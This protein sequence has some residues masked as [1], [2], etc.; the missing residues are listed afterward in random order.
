MIHVEGLST[1]TPEV[2]SSALQAGDY[3]VIVQAASAEVSSKGSQGLKLEYVVENG[4]DQTYEK[5]DGTVETQSPVGR[6]L[7]ETAWLP[8]SGQKDGGDYCARHLAKICEVLGVAQG[9]DLDEQEFIGKR[10]KVR[11]KVVTKDGE[12]NDLNDPRNEVT[13]RFEL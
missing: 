4:P 9:D 1:A 6:H 11:V 13:K 3:D 7:F 2:Y 5:R 10:C 8:H 12:G